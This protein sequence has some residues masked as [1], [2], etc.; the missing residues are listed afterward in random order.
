MESG[1]HA[2]SNLLYSL[3]YAVR[4]SLGSLD[5]S[6]SNRFLAQ[7]PYPCVYLVY[8]VLNGINRVCEVVQLYG[9]VN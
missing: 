6:P 2:R 5:V 1:G 9:G 4:Q 7:V 3:C 8:V